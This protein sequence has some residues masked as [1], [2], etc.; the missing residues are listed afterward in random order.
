MLISS[1]SGDV[2][3][4]RICQRLHKPLS[5]TVFEVESHK[6]NLPKNPQG[7]PDMG[8]SNRS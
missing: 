1:A 6:I 4:Q 5:F 2:L 8:V 3:S 7:L